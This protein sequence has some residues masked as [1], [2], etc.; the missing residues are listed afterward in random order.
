MHKSRDELPPR[1][2]KTVHLFEQFH[3]WLNQMQILVTLAFLAVGVRP[4][5][6]QG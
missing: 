1:T 5:Q 6:A 4:Q 3:T 2:G